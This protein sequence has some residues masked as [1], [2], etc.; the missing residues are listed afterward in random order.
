MQK[1]HLLK[2]STTL[3]LFVLCQLS[4]AQPV[5]KVKRS[6]SNTYSCPPATALSYNNKTYIWTA[7]G[8]WKSQDM[9]FATEVSAFKGAEW[10]GVTVGK[11]ACLYTPGT[12]DDFPIALSQNAMIKKP[13][14]NNTENAWQLAKDKKPAFNSPIKNERYV[15]INAQPDLCAF[16]P[17][18]IDKEPP[19]TQAIFQEIQKQ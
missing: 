13:I 17:V 18:D 12:P 5:I 10:Q 4:A 9:S 6:A 19:S 1:S 7:P 2:V 11:L 3:M 15:C 14:P 8:G 16:H